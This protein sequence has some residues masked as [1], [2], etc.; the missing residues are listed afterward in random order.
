MGPVMQHRGRKDRKDFGAKVRLIVIVALVSGGLLL[1]DARPALAYVDP[2][3]PGF[4]YQIG[5]LLVYGMLGTLAFFRPIR[6]LFKR[7]KE[8]DASKSDE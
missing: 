3:L 8:K 7:Q 2:A 6:R 5:Y 1:A 4:I